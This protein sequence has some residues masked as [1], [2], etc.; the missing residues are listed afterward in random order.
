[1]ACSINLGSTVILTGGFY[2]PN[3]VSEYS[4]TG[5][6]RDL[7]QL[8][9][10]RYSHGCSYFENEEGTKVDIVSHS[11][12]VII[13]QTFLVTGGEDISYNLLSST[14]L[15]VE[16]SAAWILTGELPTPRW[17]LRGA[18]IDQRVLMTG[19]K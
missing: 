14:E 15:L 19:N 1:M 4:E 12:G 10:G 13:L 17:G 16:T 5:F 3:R 7:P 8:L 11:C 9:Q 2:S 18:N 6:T